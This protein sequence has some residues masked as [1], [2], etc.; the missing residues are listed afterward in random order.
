[1]LNKRRTFDHQGQLYRVTQNMYFQPGKV[2]LLSEEMASVANSTV[3]NGSVT[4]NPSVAVV[5]P[6]DHSPGTPVGHLLD[7]P[8]FAP[9]AMVCS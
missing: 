2:Q 1:M 8:Q 5:D 3:A 9:L 4:S 6:G 7:V